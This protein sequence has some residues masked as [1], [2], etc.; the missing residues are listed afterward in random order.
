MVSPPWSPPHAFSPKGDVDLLVTH[1]TRV[2]GIVHQ[3]RQIQLVYHS[4]FMLKLAL[5][6]GTGTS[7][8]H[9][10]ACSAS[11][12][13]TDAFSPPACSSY[14]P[15]CSSGSALRLVARVRFPS[16]TPCPCLSSS[17]PIR[18]HMFELAFVTFFPAGTSTSLACPGS[19][20]APYRRERYLHILYVMPAARR[21]CLLTP[22]ILD[23]WHNGI[24]DSI[25]T[26]IPDPNN[27]FGIIFAMFWSRSKNMG[28]ISWS[29]CIQNTVSDSQNLKMSLTKSSG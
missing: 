3:H 18:S 17:T 5:L 7:C 1:V 16:Q 15:R 26:C 8:P 6:A 21:V 23:E 2:V 20:S 9:S 14:Y 19:P 10:R 22:I 4:V 11:T 24:H 25:S 28:F 27:L 29:P 12:P 13:R